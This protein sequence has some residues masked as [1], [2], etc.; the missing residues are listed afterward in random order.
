MADRI[1][2]IQSKMTE[3]LEQGNLIA[4]ISYV[5]LVGWIY[6]YLA[7][8]EDKLCQFHSYQALQLN[9]VISVIYFCV[10]LIENF[11]IINLLF[12]PGAILHPISR[13]IWLISL[14]IYLTVSAVGAYQ[15][16]GDN[17][18]EIPYL[19]KGITTL[20]QHIKKIFQEK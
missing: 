2:D 14:F 9:I 6:P 3:Q 20:M 4:A 18:W 13:T 7:R 17:E 16:F 8:R 10:W 1:R 11:I 15:A 5:P 12:G 19:K